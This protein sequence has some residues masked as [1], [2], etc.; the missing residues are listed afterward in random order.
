M[1]ITTLGEARIGFLPL[2]CLS[3]PLV[4]TGGGGGSSLQPRF[5][6]RAQLPDLPCFRCCF[7]P[8]PPRN[9]R[10]EYQKETALEGEEIE[11]NCT[12]MASRPVT[13]IRWFKGSKPLLGRPALLD[14]LKG[15]GGG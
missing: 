6:I 7:L 4:Y 15:K 9:L 10:I 3:P 12:A 1:S 14:P 11:L 5:C 8:V 13:T 2:V